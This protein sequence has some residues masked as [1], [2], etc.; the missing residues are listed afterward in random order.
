MTMVK[1]VE[2]VLGWLLNPRIDFVREKVRRK[3]RAPLRCQKCAPAFGAL[4]RRI[5]AMSRQ[6]PGDCRATDLVAE[7]Q[8]CV[9]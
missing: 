3:Y 7:I 1:W 9:S 6:D 8:K 4:R 5:D 2:A